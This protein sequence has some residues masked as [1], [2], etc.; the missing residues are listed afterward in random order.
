MNL[1][2]DESIWI[3]TMAHEW[4][5]VDMLKMV[6]YMNDVETVVDIGACIGLS[7]RH[8]VKHLKPNKIVAFEPI[9]RNIEIMDVFLGPMENV[10]VRD[11]GIF[12]GKTSSTIGHYNNNNLAG[13]FVSSLKN[14]FGREVF[15]DKELVMQLRELEDEIDFI[16][17][18]IKIDVEGSEYNI[19]E[20]SKIVKQAKYLFV[21]WHL[22]KDEYINNF[23]SKTLND[24]DVLFCDKRNSMLFERKKEC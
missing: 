23:I 15:E 1:T 9:K 22:Q 16:P 19:I 18:L 11:V 5:N 10:D 13:K 7:V 3:N 4:K 20:N 6:K 17:D 2:N 14:N 24:Y 8:W 12:Y 21:E